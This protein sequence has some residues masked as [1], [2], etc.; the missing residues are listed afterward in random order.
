MRDSIDL[1]ICS[2]FITIS[3]G[4]IV[5]GILRGSFLFMGPNTGASSLKR[6]KLSLSECIKAHVYKTLPLPLHAAATSLPMAQFSSVMFACPTGAR[7][8][9]SACRARGRGAVHT[10]RGKRNSKSVRP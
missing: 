9:I 6:E 4:A 10:G 8:L 2:N 3:V 7:T 1:E 5:H